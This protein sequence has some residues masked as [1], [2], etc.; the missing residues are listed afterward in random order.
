M[1]YAWYSDPSV[2][3]NWKIRNVNGKIYILSPLGKQYMN[4]ALALVDMIRNKHS[5]DD[6]KEMREKLH[7]EGWLL[8]LPSNTL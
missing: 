6:I 8:F 2:P 1:S 3:D 5:E 7:L 4:R